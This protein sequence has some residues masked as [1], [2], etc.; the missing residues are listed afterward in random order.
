MLV[1]FC[2]P[3][4]E[5]K[6]IDVKFLGKKKAAAKFL[7]H[8]GGQSARPVLRVQVNCTGQISKQN[9]HKL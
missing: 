7:F 1:I 2:L 6:I 5:K 3:Y 4:S 8:N 9:F